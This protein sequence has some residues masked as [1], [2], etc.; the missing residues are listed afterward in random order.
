MI[1]EK[2][3]RYFLG[4]LE[5]SDEM[6]N[7][8]EYEKDVKLMQKLL[9]SYFDTNKEM[10]K[11][12][13]DYVHILIKEYVVVNKR[14]AE[15]YLSVLSHALNYDKDY[16]KTI[17]AQLLQRADNGEKLSKT[18]A[19]FM[20]NNLIV[21]DN[22]HEQRVNT[23]ATNP[24]QYITIMHPKKVILININED[25]TQLTNTNYREMPNYQQQ[26]INKVIKEFESVETA[27]F[28]NEPV[29]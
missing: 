21:V 27:A 26:F 1:N 17:R 22:A 24:T 9:H 23:D 20:A 29:K 2:A 4:L 12:D 5:K 11:F 13:K 8:K 3:F 16:R 10:S 15:K 25:S 18:D 28:E 7:T 6:A 19:I 14:E